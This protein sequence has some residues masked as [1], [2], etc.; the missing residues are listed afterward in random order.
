MCIRTT[1]HDTTRKHA[2][3][4]SRA[5]WYCCCYCAKN[6]QVPRGEK[7][8]ERTV[9]GSSHLTVSLE[10]TL[11]LVLARH[12]TR[13]FER[14]RISM[15]DTSPRAGANARYSPRLMHVAAPSA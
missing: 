15:E 4:L 8:N 11:G 6:T 2:W 3:L 10:G 14:N 1:Q 5:G 12:S 9:R 7:V 13:R